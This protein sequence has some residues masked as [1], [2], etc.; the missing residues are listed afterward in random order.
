MEIG[1]LRYFGHK[2]CSK[3]AKFINLL[4]MCHFCPSGCTLKTTF[5]NSPTGDFCPLKIVD[6]FERFLE[7]GVEKKIGFLMH[8]IGLTWYYK[9]TIF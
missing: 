1:I 8:L 5:F 2:N 7:N 4:P 6:V 3:L 9:E